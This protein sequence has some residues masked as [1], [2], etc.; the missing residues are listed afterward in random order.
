VSRLFGDVTV[1]VPDGSSVDLGGFAPFGDNICR[2]EC[3]D[4]DGPEVHVR[5][6]GAFGDVE[7]MTRSQYAAEQAREAAEERREDAEERR[8]DAEER[9]EERREELEDGG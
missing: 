2:G 6:F 9:R 8:E 3:A 5:T 1:V 7:V 4:G